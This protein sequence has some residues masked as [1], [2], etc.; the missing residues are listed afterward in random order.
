M[1]HQPERA[2]PATEPVTPGEMIRLMD[3]I[4]LAVIDGHPIPTDSIDQLTPWRARL[5]VA[6]ALAAGAPLQHGTPE[7]FGEAALAAGTTAPSTTGWWRAA[8]DLPARPR[9]EA[10][11]RNTSPSIP[12]GWTVRKD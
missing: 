2:G 4:L 12:Y 3:D 5:V 7:L 10:S 1:T 8:L 9:P 11:H 6:V